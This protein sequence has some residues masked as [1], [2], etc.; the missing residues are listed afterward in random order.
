M[1]IQSEFRIILFSAKFRRN[2]IEEMSSNLSKQELIKVLKQFGLDVS[3]KTPI[4]I[5]QSKFNY[6]MKDSDSES[7]ETT[8]VELVSCS[9]EPPERKPQQVNIPKALKS[10][11]AAKKIQ[12]DSNV[13]TVGDSAKQCQIPIESKSE[14]KRIP[15]QAAVIKKVKFDPKTTDAIHRTTTIRSALKKTE[16]RNDID[17]SCYGKA[18][19]ADSE[20]HRTQFRES[21]KAIRDLI[22]EKNIVANETDDEETKRIKQILNQCELPEESW[23]DIVKIDAQQRE[24]IENIEAIGSEPT[25]RTFDLNVSATINLS[26]SGDTVHINQS[27][28]IGMPS[29]S[30]ETVAL[31]SSVKENVLDSD[32]G[33]KIFEYT[34]QMQSNSDRIVRMR[35]EKKIIERPQEILKLDIKILRSTQ[36]DSQSNSVID[37]PTVIRST[38]ENNFAIRS[39]I[40]N[41][42]VQVSVNK[43]KNELNESKDF[44]YNCSMTGHKSFR[45]PHPKRGKGTCFRCGS[46][47]HIFKDCP[48]KSMFRSKSNQTSKTSDK[49]W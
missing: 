26:D 19:C 40:S 16:Q 6:C 14:S 31:P 23:A 11:E 48:N 2:K 22:E 21:V 33:N 20:E 7:D 42:S 32:I 24:E 37:T 18:V 4:N 1:K 36:T 9:V 41:T 34:N 27:N 49:E 29:P 46:A 47:S 39:T 12:I 28:A 15:K 10:I 13:T 8:V 30:N 38:V 35:N 43:N 3:C 45:C 17:S 25:Y 44:C 5:L